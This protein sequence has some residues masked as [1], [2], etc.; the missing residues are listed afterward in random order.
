MALAPIT[1]RDKLQR[2]TDLARKTARYWWMIALFALAGGALS[3]AFAVFKP[4]NYQSWS[5][6]FYQ[7]QIGRA[8]V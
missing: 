7:E 6:L 3:L 1:P 4:K 8:H 5:T 2:I